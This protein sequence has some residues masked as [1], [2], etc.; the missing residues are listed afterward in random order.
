MQ[1]CIDTYMSG[2]FSSQHKH[3]PTHRLS[4]PPPL[5]KTLAATAAA[6]NTDDAEPRGASNRQRLLPFPPEFVAFVDASRPG[7]NRLL[8]GMP[9]ALNGH[10]AML[11][12]MPG[13][14]EGG[15]PVFAPFV[16]SPSNTHTRTAHGTRH[17]QGRWRRGRSW[18]S[19]WC[20]SSGRPTSPSVLC[21]I[22]AYLV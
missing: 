4:T 9:D 1:Q 5:L 3:R 10:L 15:R 8:A 18:S 7:L 20:S 16:R 19:W 22:G 17:M 12:R 2:A 13:A 21:G 6:H 11:L 14:C